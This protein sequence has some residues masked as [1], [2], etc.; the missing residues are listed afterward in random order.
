MLVPRLF[1][2]PLVAAAATTATA[3]VD[4]S[5]IIMSDAIKAIYIHI[6][7]MCAYY[8]HTDNL[9]TFVA[10]RAR[11]RRFHGGFRVY[12][13]IVLRRVCGRGAKK[14]IIYMYYMCIHTHTHTHIHTYRNKERTNEGEL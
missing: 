8:K 11:E 14:I 6:V 7:Y 9:A 4:I 10:R 12:Y 1:S 2:V 3:D 13:F 5:I